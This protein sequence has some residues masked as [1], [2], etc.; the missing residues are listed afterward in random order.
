MSDTNPKSLHD[1]MRRLQ[2]LMNS[3]KID[4]INYI[5]TDQKYDEISHLVRDVKD[6]EEI[7]QWVRD[8]FKSGGS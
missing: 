7:I 5:N 3:V 1:A 2:V 6:A 4:L 8:T